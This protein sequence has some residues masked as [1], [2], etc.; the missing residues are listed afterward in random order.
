MQTKLTGL[1]VPVS[2]PFKDNG[3][4]DEGRLA[5]HC[6]KL[7]DD[8]ATGLAV[9]G[10]TSEAN[11]LTL[12]ERRRVID[13]L[14]EAGIPAGQLLPGTGACAI[15]DAVA[16]SKHAAGH[17]AAGVLL[18]PPFYYKNVSDDGLFAFVSSVIERCGASPPRILLYHF[19][20]MAA[21]GWSVALTGRLI[22]AFPGIVAGMKDSSGNADNTRTMIES[23]PGFAVFPGAEIYLLP[24]LRWGGAGCISATANINA[25]GIS[26]L[27][28]HQH[29]PDAE[30]RQ[31]GLNAIRKSFDGFVTV[32][33][34]KAVIAAQTGD[35]GW[36]NVRPPLLPLTE[37]ERRTL[38][39]K[40]A[41]AEL[42]ARVP[43]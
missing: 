40:P 10:T 39:S 15:D 43:A 41:I 21:A 2:T 16:L 14:V 34:V 13:A 38:L 5:R 24:A 26:S 4:V 31:E 12:S 7:L 30:A 27:I 8:G 25:H 1:W 28:R 9:L 23:Y 22:K 18:L 42:L 19:P 36:S 3:E 32:P 37:Q 6:R 35:A 17:G 11:S 20:Q 29:D 33:A